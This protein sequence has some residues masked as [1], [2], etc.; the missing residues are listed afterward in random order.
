MTDSENA[1]IHTCLLLT[2]IACVAVWASQMRMESRY[3]T[4]LDEMKIAGETVRVEANGLEKN[5]IA[6]AFSCFLMGFFV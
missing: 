1:Y 6:H 4:I 5:G 3:D 2:I